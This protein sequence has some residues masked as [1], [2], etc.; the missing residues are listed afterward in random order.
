MKG[1]SHQDLAEAEIYVNGRVQGVGFRPFV[2][3]LAVKNNLKGYVINLGDAGVEIVVEGL[4]KCIDTFIEKIILE[5]P[6]VSEVKN[7]EKRFRPF[8]NRFRKFTIDRSRNGTSVTSGVFPPDIGICPDCLRD[9]MNSKSRWYEHPFTACAWCGPRFTGLISLPYDRERT[10]MNN[11]PMC[12]H[13][14]AEYNDPMDRR[15]DAQGITCS[16]C[17]P[18]M[19]LH[20]EKGNK[21]ETSDVFNEAATLLKKGK[22]IAIKGIGGFHLS[23]IATE[24]EPI[25]IL[26]DRK[27]RPQQPFALM[28]PNLDSIVTFTNPDPQETEALTGWRKP[29]V[30]LKKRGSLISE[31]VAPGLD[32]LGVMLPYSGIHVLL[33]KRLK[34][35]A[36]IMTSGNRSS[37]PMAITNEDAFNELNGIAD[38][39]LIHNRS[40]IS[41]CDDSLLRINDGKNAFIRRSRGFVPDP[42]EIPFKKGVAIALGTEYSN[43]AAITKPGQCYMTQYL[44]D[45]SSL[46]TLDYEKNAINRLREVLKIT[47][48]PDVIACDMHPG[49]LTSQLAQEMSHETGSSIVRSQHHH[50]H[51]VSVCAE[52]QVPLDESVVGIALDGAGFGPDGT[53]WGGEILISTYSNYNRAGHLE[54][55][56]M[57]GGD[58]STFYPFK[59]VISSLTKSMSDDEIRDITQNHINRALLNKKEELEIILKQS[60]SPHVLKTSSSGR[61]LDSISSL[62]GLC[63]H[64]TY[65]GEPAMK[66][67][68]LAAKGDRNKI[69]LKPL[70]IEDKNEYYLKTDN[71]VRFLILNQNNFKKQDVAAFSQKY[72]A[73]GIADIAINV[74][75]DQGIDKIAI[76]GG[77]L[78]NTSIY[79]II[80]SK[81]ELANINVISNKYVPLG[82]GGLALGQSCI[83]LSSVM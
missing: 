57:P 29:I 51:I 44:G 69:D 4:K 10:H 58:S 19:S 25:I 80:S 83:A 38:Y 12:K 11:F 3:R 53:I 31:L 70:I 76:T 75:K 79:H 43:S 9:M 56:P 78:V 46:E 35:P 21:I 24:D 26:R 52:N 47:R 74:C 82:D 14:S 65:E 42:I 50:A 54:L 45:V 61:F 81:I 72:L 60:R 41:R 5:A 33:F 71:V 8:S 22:I 55:I 2:Y 1:L 16:L 49:Y 66:L 6:E 68:A 7:V 77:V 73:E 59:M 67:E 20:D 39:F 48:N 63:Y 62:L 36:L 28:S 32:R 64:R 30:L 13:C 15:F 40:I 27:K 37:L 17:G 18:L 34:E 23:S